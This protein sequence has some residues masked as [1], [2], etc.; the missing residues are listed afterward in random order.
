MRSKTIEQLCVESANYVI[1]TID[2]EKCLTIKLIRD[3]E[4]AEAQL[5]TGFDVDIEFAARKEALQI[6]ANNILANKDF[7]TSIKSAVYDVLSKQRVNG[8]PRLEVELE[9]DGRLCNVDG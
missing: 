2:I 4:R 1:E 7:A 8:K 6:A 3:T 5:C 9:Y